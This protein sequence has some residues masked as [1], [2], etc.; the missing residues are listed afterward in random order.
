MLVREIDTYGTLLKFM[1]SHRYIIIKEK[2]VYL[3]E[4]K[5]KFPY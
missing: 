4:K 2:N 5:L 1:V 3:E